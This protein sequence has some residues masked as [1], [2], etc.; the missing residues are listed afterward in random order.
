MRKFN[1]K[2]KIS[3]HEPELL[4]RKGE[5]NININITCNDETGE[6]LNALNTM[7]KAIKNT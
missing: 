2:L 5:R 7:Q 6:L 4:N 3:N 1:R